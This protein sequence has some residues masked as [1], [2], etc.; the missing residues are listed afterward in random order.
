MNANQSTTFDDRDLY[1]QSVRAVNAE[2]TIPG[3]GTFKSELTQVTLPRVWMQRSRETLPRIAWINGRVARTPIYFLTSP[4]QA[5]VGMCATTISPGDIMFFGQDLSRHE[6]TTGPVQWGTMSLAIEDFA[7]SAR[8]LLGH[9]VKPPAEARRVRPSAALMERLVALHLGTSEIVRTTPRRLA[10]PEVA[11]ALDH[12][13]VHAM[14]RCL[15]NG[16]PD[17][18]GIGHRRNSAIIVRLEELL[19]ENLD[20]PLYLADLCA[21]LGL[22]ERTLRYCC[23]EHLGMGPIRYLWLR[24]MHLAH[25]ALKRGT[26]G[27]T[28]VTAIATGCGF[29]EMGRFAG[30]YRKL[31]GEQPSVT[32]RRPSDGRIA[33]PN[34]PGDLRVA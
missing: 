22:S 7:A 4:N 26:P 23:E 19:A 24:R 11:R 15:T 33:P 6:R 17:T 14:V 2:L 13:L 1:Q 20:R 10:K 32:L 27:A 21:D 28:T 12:A 31:F 29:W 34:R 25:S 9:D 16:T 5:P 18:P 30:A 8:A 3:K